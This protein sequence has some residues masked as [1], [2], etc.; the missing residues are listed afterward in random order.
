MSQVYEDIR[1]LPGGADARRS[2]TGWPSYRQLWPEVA[3]ATGDNGENETY[4][5][6]LSEIDTTNFEFPPASCPSSQSRSCSIW[7]RWQFWS[8][9]NQKGWETPLDTAGWHGGHY[10]SQAWI[11]VPI[12]PGEGSEKLVEVEKVVR[13]R[14]AAGLELILIP[15]KYGYKDMW[16]WA[17]L[18]NRFARSS[19]NTIGIIQASVD[20]NL[21]WPL[22]ETVFPLD[23]LQEASEYED[24]G[25]D[26][27]TVRDTIH[28]ET[29]ELQRTVDTLPHL[30]GQLNIPVDAVGMV[31][32]RDKSPM[33]PGVPAVQSEQQ[34]S[35]SEN[36]DDTSIPKASIASKED[37]GEVAQA[38]QRETTVEPSSTETHDVAGGRAAAVDDNPAKSLKGNPSQEVQQTA[39]AGANAAMTE[40][41]AR[42]G[43]APSEADS[44][45]PAGYERV[46]TKQSGGELVVPTRDSVSN[47][48]T[49]APIDKNESPAAKAPAGDA[50]TLRESVPVGYT[51]Q[52]PTAS[53]QAIVADP[54]TELWSEGGGL[55]LT[56]SLAGALA[57]SAISVFL[58]VRFR[59]RRG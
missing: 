7:K 34:H 13:E 45:I 33:G 24:G 18:L 55:L 46:S 41:T 8:A 56:G 25:L 39:G 21:T 5:F 48:A 53:D 59:R 14:H 54:N 51:S 16:H 58:V 35:K 29:L 43:T 28:L 19:G 52:T 1:L 49:K 31:Y 57:V 3:K 2:E 17:E 6:D 38:D 37:S 32:R 47:A 12:G 9:L 22:S 26:Y 15:V 23:S 50:I 20:W 36:A 10:N 4:S 40:K 30:L 11:Q 27:N 44:Q 42:D